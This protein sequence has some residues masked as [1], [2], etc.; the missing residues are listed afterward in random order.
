MTSLTAAFGAT[1][2]RDMPAEQ[3]WQVGRLR[4]LIA[5]SDLPLD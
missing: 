2:A 4:E 5:V 3:R 1:A